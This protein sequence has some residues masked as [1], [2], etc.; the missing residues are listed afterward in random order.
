MISI[1]GSEGEGGGQVL[2]TAISLSAI[3]GTPVRIENI[4]AGRRKPGLMRQHFT[5][6]SAAAEICGASTEGLALKS[7][8][9]SFTPSEIKGGNY[10][11][12]IGSA[13]GT[14]LVA[15]TVLPILSF[16]KTKS[17]ISVKGGT[18]NQ[19]APTYD[20]LDQA[21]LPLFRKMGGRADLALDGYGFYPAGGG[22]I[23]LS[24]EPHATPVALMLKERGE[25]ISKRVVAIVSNLKR[26][27]AQREVNK[28]AHRMNFDPELAEII[29]AESPGP[30]NIVSLFIAYANVSEVFVGIGQ[31][32]VRAEAV[33]NGVVD[34]AREFFTS[35]A[36]VGP[37]LADQLLLPM[38][39]LGGG[40]F[41]TSEVTEH[42][43]TNIDIIKRF[44]AV[45]IEVRQ[46][47]RKLWQIEVSV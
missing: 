2:R 8:T 46:I 31:N 39:L 35:G 16:A 36:A 23:T 4:R 24:V 32:G 47:E 29:H 13:G 27:I 44:L 38:A 26:E 45:R 22:K 41:T 5:A 3:T 12:A 28:I 20:Y 19:W 11:F 40:V 7:D 33:A 9:V 10:E 25:K 30:G 14:C 6:I 34:E 17:M 21:F 15:Q 43:S 37:H 42:T 18:H 1:D